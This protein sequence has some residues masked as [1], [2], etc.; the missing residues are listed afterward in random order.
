MITPT[1]LAEYF[2]RNLHIIK[3]QTEGLSHADSLIQLPF[4]SNCMNWVLGHLV[5]NRLTVL[6]LLE[7]Q[8][9]FDPERLAH[10]G[11][12]SEPVTGEGEGV[13][14]MEELLGMIESLDV[15]IGKRL[16]EISEAALNHEI[17]FFGD[18]KRPVAEWIFFFYFH[19]AYHTGQTEIL[20]QA[21]GKDDHII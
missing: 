6:K 7:G 11:H 3:Q 12:G 5:T 17:A 9:P 1:L 16:S 18:Q 19:D 2:S 13:L 20:R 21:A 14:R 8:P 15:E 4:R 10:Y